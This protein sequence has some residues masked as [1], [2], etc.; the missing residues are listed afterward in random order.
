MSQPER[1][2]G[3][4]SEPE[5]ASRFCCCWPRFRS[6]S[7]TPPPRADVGTQSVRQRAP[8]DQQ[9]SEEGAE[10]GAG[11][12]ESGDARYCEDCEMWLNG[13]TQWEDHKI[14]KKHKTNVK[15]G[16]ANKSAG[17]S[18]GCSQPSTG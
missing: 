18:H 8:A 1:S 9:L 10:S 4:A 14:G 2:A 17:T 3:D 5:S 7:R 15:K 12:P 6:R 11:A 13:P 16:G